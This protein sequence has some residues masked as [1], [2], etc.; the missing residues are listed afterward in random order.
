MHAVDC[1]RALTSQRKGRRLT[2]PGQ[3]NLT[4]WLE[5]AFLLQLCLHHYQIDLQEIDILTEQTSSEHY[6]RIVI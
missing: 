1:I 3:V 4:M 6:S 5:I 2:S